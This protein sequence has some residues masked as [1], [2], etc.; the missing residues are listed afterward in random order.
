[1]SFDQDFLDE[2]NLLLLYDLK[3]E[4]DG[5][6]IHHDATPQMRDAAKRLHAKGI[7]TQADGGYLTELG[8]KAADHA[9]ALRMMLHG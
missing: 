4:Q 6:K 8:R 7:I 9:D 5:L 3:N 2:L 1:M